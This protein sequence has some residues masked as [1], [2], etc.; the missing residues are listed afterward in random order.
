MRSVLG[1][2]VASAATPGQG[3][4]G[5]LSTEALGLLP[6]ARAGG[7]SCCE[8]GFFAFRGPRRRGGKRRTGGRRLPGT[9]PVLSWEGGR[10]AVCRAHTERRKSF[11]P[12][13]ASTQT[14]LG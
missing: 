12:R 6:E 7:Q 14:R 9:R 5:P 10:T 1:R 4:N 13:G 11:K 3:S 2:P 8:S